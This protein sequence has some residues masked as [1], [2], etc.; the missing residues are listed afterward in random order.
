MNY[1]TEQEKFWA[2]EFGNDYP[3]RN[4]GEELIASNVA[5]F[6]KILK[7]CPNVTSIA[8]LGCNIGLNLIAL[9]R[10]NKNLNLRG[11]EINAISAKEAGVNSVAE[12]INTTVIEKLDTTSQFDLTFTKG[13]LIHINPEQLSKVYQNLYDLSKKYI[14]VCEYYNPT[15]MTLDYRGNKDKLFKRDFAGELISKY[16]LKLADYGFNYHLDTYHT[17]DDSTWFLLEK[18][19]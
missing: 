9:N 2:T 13:V 18:S 7:N 6:S 15:P 19:S 10:I 3:S 1:Q 17:N 11:Y 14:M 16:N 4:M 8:E 5:L 12:I